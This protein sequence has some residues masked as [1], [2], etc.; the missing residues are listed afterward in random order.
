MDCFGLEKKKDYFQS[1]RTFTEEELLSIRK[2]VI[3]MNASDEDSEEY[4]RGLE[5]A[6]FNLDYIMKE[7]SSFPY[8]SNYRQP[9][10]HQMLKSINRNILEYTTELLPFEKGSYRPGNN[11]KIGDIM[12]PSK[13]EFMP[14]IQ[15][16]F[17]WYNETE[18]DIF[19]KLSVFHMSFLKYIHPFYN[20]NGR[21]IRAFINL[22]LARSGYPMIGIKHGNI[23]E[24]YDSFEL[25]DKDGYQLMEEL[26]RSSVD[27][28]LDRLI[29]VKK[30]F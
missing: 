1:L 8:P 3:R 25:K 22:E 5:L 15:M 12:L 9:L 18:I 20:G 7:E 26:I 28:E 24:Y 16:I 23:E 6:Y 27:E 10:S 21:T 17:D 11:D 2:H 19:R 14:R 29:L 30:S 4:F 13:E